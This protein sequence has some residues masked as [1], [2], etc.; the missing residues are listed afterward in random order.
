MSTATTVNLTSLGVGAG[1][2]SAG[3][4]SQLV[5]VAQLPLTALQT[6]QT[7]ITSASQTISAFST[8][9]SA[10]QTAASALSDPLQYSS[11]TASSSDPS[12]VASSSGS[13]L[14]G[15][16]TVQVLTLA[17]AQRTNGITES[18]N[19]G[20]LGLSGTL[21]IT[22]GSNTV[23]V[24]IAAGDS[25]ATIAANI[26]SSGARVGAS[27]MFDG[28]NYRLQLQGLDSGAANAVT[29]AESGFTLGLSTPANTLQIAQD[30]S[31]KV[32]GI[33]V[34]SPTN[35]LTNAIPGV[36]LALT[37]VSTATV[38]VAADSNALS[39]KITAFI[40]AYNSVVTAGHTAA[41][42]GTVVATNALLAGDRG[43]ET[44]LSRLS[45]LVV[46]TVPGATGVYQSLSSV[47][48]HTQ[49][50]GTLKLDSTALAA[51]VQADPVRVERLFVTDPTNGST[52]I[53]KTFS[54][55]IDA[56]ANNSGSPLQSELATFTA[57]TKAI[58]VHMADMQRRLDAY[59]AQLKAE[60]AAM[61]QEVTK[62]R[63]LFNEVGGSGT[64]V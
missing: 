43:I 4:T 41:G 58:T 9:L 10:L 19:T 60:F 53:M 17:Q 44:S 25:L 18:S 48:I 3:I 24:P 22:I 47:G 29:F 32:D 28:T 52:G 49:A 42:Y 56:L 51:A 2:D 37:A 62:Q 39:Q 12:V 33:N 1:I 57:R 20:A 26:S 7:S 61:D 59:T 14:P 5:A 46:N 15:S 23:N 13:P 27:V 50:D 36:K 6:T 35:Q 45:A 64:F 30:A 55:A 63:A 40:T 21:G 38:T 34:T 54:T 16:H 11:Y 8:Q 31:A